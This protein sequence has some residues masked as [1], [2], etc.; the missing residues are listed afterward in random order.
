[1]EKHLLHFFF[2]TIFVLCWYDSST[3]NQMGMDI[4]MYV[5]GYGFQV[6]VGIVE[7]S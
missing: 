6:S 4:Y 1:M 3:T 7:A 2:V 5:C